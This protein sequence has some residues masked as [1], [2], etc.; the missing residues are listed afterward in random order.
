MNHDL[1]NRIAVWLEAGAPHETAP[2]GIGFNM[3]VAYEDSYEAWRDGKYDTEDCGSACCIAG[4]A[5]Q[6][7][8]L[9]V[10]HQSDQSDQLGPVY[11]KAAEL[12]GL[13]MNEAIDLFFP[14]EDQFGGC[15]VGITPQDAA[16]VIRHLQATGRTD[17]SII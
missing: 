5:I 7:A 13:S 4:A 12:L 9:S 10:P 14:D 16:K 8:G 2:N 6:F 11:Q 1:L 3:V 17:W 15:W